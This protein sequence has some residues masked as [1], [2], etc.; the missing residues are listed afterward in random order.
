MVCRYQIAVLVAA[1][2]SATS[3]HQ[4]GNLEIIGGNGNGICCIDFMK[5]RFRN[6]PSYILLHLIGRA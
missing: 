1:V 5:I 4:G 6:M 2:S 3:L